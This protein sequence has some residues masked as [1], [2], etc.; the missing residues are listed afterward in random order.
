MGWNVLGIGQIE[1]NDNKQ[2]TKE[3][4]H[5]IYN[6]LKS[7]KNDIYNLTEMLD[8]KMNGNKGINYK[9]LDEL[10]EWSIIEKL[11]I[12]I[13]V[14]E[15]S[16]CDGGFYYEADLDNNEKSDDG[17]KDVNDTKINKKHI[18]YYEQTNTLSI[19]IEAKNKEEAKNKADDVLEQQSFN[20]NVNKSQK[21]YFE[22]TYT[23]EV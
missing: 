5:K 15:Y 18:V 9:V 8:F 7:Y 17:N 12:T 21:G 10:T 4:S 14:N 11:N 19:E 2:N 23:D 3:N 13:S 22:Y 1:F 6:K 20:E 16:E